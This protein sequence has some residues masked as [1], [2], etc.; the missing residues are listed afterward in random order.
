[1]NRGGR[2]EAVFV[3]LLVQ[4]AAWL[5][6]GVAAL[7]F[8]IAGERVMLLLGLLTFL[9]GWATFWLATALLL[10]VRRAR[11]IVL[12][13]EWLCLLWSLAQLLLPFGNGAAPV[14]VLSGVA[15]PLTV[16][17]LLHGRRSRLDYAART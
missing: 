13:L 2:R 15:L 16:L 3:L 10:R 9:F 5:L 14:M 11:G 17:L 1:M 7:V 12:T 8:G 4:G 6:A